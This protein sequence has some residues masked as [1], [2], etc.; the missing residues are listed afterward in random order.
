MSRQSD[1]GSLAA[2]SAA[3]AFSL[4]PRRGIFFRTMAPADG[5]LTVKSFA[6][7]CLVVQNTALVMLMRHSRTSGSKGPMYISS[8]AV[9]VMEVGFT[10]RRPT[11]CSVPLKIYFRLVITQFVKLF[12]CFGVVYVVRAPSMLA[13]T[14]PASFHDNPS[15]HSLCR[16]HQLTINLRGK[17][18]QK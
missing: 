16:L 12:T 2:G 3:A 17:S 15:F 5:S 1:T 7:V 11:C 9:F 13:S 14:L 18:Q 6:L 8:T 4:R 10:C